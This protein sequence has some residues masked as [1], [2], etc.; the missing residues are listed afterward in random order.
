M[1]AG[2]H[3]KRKAS[4]TNQRSCLDWSSNMQVVRKGS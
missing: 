4:A 1:K 2:N 3:P